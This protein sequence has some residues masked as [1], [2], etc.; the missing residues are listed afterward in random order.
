MKAASSSVSVLRFLSLLARPDEQVLTRHD[1]FDC[2]AI[3]KIVSA[4]RRSCLAG[5]SEPSDWPVACSPSRTSESGWR[6]R[7]PEPD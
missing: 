6:G 1:L 4:G 3:D 7:R 5:P 2:V